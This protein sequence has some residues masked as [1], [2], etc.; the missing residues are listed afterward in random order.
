MTKYRIRLPSGRVLGPFEERELFDLKTKGHIKGLEEAQEFP[1]GN[2]KAIQDFPFYQDLMD[3]NKTAISSGSNNNENTFVIDLT[4][5]RN[6]QKEKEIEELVEEEPAPPIEPMTET[7]RMGPTEKKIA[8]EELDDVFEKQPEGTSVTKSQHGFDID[9]PTLEDEEKAKREALEGKTVINPIA[10]EEIARMRREEQEEK[11]RIE[12]EAE[13]KLRQEE[14]KRQYELVVAQEN[15]PVTQDES[16][17]MIKLDKTGLLES[18]LEA[19]SDIEEELKKFQ[20]KK[21]KE[22]ARARANEEDEE[23]DEDTGAGKKKKI[24]IIAAALAIAYAFLF[25]EE[26]PKK[27]PFQHI[28]P[29]IVFPI[30]FDKADSRKSK[31]EF[32]QGIKYFESGT[33]PNIVRAGLSF[34][35]SY[36]NDLENKEALNFMVRTYAE[37][38]QHSKNKLYDAQTLFNLIQSKRPF[39]TENPNGAIGLN[40]FYMAINKPNAASDVVEKYLKLKPKNITQDLFAVYLKSLIKQGKLDLASQFYQALEKAPNKNRY[41]LTALIQYLLLNQETDKAMEYADDAIKKFPKIASLYLLKAEL[42]IKQKKVD[43]AVPLIKKAEDLNLDYNNLNR[44][45]FFELKG[46]SYGLKGKP[47]EAA[48]Y[49]GYSLKLNDSD[50]LRIKL[51]ELETSN[52]Q[53]KD[54]DNLI[55]ESRAVKLLLQAKDFFD[56]KNYELA[57]SSAAKATDAFPGHI[58]SE[59]FLA[60]VQLRL[61]LAEQGL[62]TLEALA[63]KYPD[64]K[65][66]NLALIEAYIATYKFND[67]RNRIQIVSSSEYRDSW[68]YASVNAKLHLAMGDSLQAMSWLKNSTSLNPLNDEDIFILADILTKKANFKAARILLNK[69]MELDP[70]NPD[71]R[72]AYARIIYETQDDRAAIGY[73]LSLLEEFGD[74]AKVLSEIAI[75]YYRS[76]QVK[77]FQDYKAKL[78]K[79]HSQDKA[80]YEFL[81]KAALLDERMGDIPVLVEKLLAIEPGEIE[82]MMTAGRVLF[83]QGKLVEAAKWF[84]RIQDKL[85]SYPMVLYYIAKIDFLTGDLDGALKKIQADMKENGENDVDLVFMA[86]IYQEKEQYVEAENLF[87]KAQ[88]IN[89]RSYDAIVGLADLSTKRNNHDLA[90]DLYKRAMKLKSDEP[91]VHKKVGDVYRQLGQGALAIEAYKLYLEM[92]PESPYRKNLEAYINLMK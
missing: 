56:K 59:L 10:Q 35:N 84:K 55:N 89:P 82:Q 38:L 7:I 25:P 5:L 49:L 18:A 80:L 70:I 73:L 67:A 63:G 15:A 81:I 44:A 16:T 33:Y 6:Q 66:I 52:G 50:D 39:L 11:A 20:K 60:K 34:K 62:K 3:E 2:W 86:Q 74:S 21:K 75:M 54:V 78:E 17:Q 85:P 27:P 19:E 32:N 14:E 9:T 68:E 65:Q 4:S 1:T 23:E 77:A 40:L 36:E 71:Y 42:L 92:E 45:K 87:K 57:L 72:I 37:E 12:R 43:E 31:V 22:E 24:I 76:G 69:C 53:M 13:E 61:G 29:R 41:G 88:K 8:L 28:E 90:L 30:P 58:P 51:A 83:E 26:K 64:D 46:L 79:H 48:K 91:L 47:N